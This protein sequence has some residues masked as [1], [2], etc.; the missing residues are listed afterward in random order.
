MNGT[1]RPKHPNTINGL[2]TVAPT[3]QNTHKTPL[4][5]NRDDVRRYM[6][7]NKEIFS[8]EESTT[9]MNVPLSTGPI[10]P[11][12]KPLEENETRPSSR[13]SNLTKVPPK[14]KEDESS[15]T[16]SSS[17]YSTSSDDG[18]E[19]N[20]VPDYVKNDPILSQFFTKSISELEKNKV[21]IPY[22]AIQRL[23]D[24]M[25]ENGDM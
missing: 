9:K 7:E 5:R 6:S 19:S 10:R 3:I 2:F 25:K 13:P 22:F 20:S 17:S 15:S 1:N 18:E 16:S 4:I 23:F 12:L 14:I 11:P 24:K 8:K 21:E